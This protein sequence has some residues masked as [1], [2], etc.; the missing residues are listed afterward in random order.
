MPGL[1]FCTT[2]LTRGSCASHRWQMAKVSS[3]ARGEVRSS[4]SW[5]YPRS[6]ERSVWMVSSMENVSEKTVTTT[7]TC[8]FFEGH[9]FVLSWLIRLENYLSTRVASQSAMTQEYGVGCPRPPNGGYIQQQIQCAPR[10]DSGRRSRGIAHS[11]AH[12]GECDQEIDDRAG[13]ANP[14]VAR[15]SARIRRIEMLLFPPT[16]R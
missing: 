13:Y 5:M 11:L 6:R 14:F 4:I 9:S 16:G 7:E 15:Q 12:S 2:T 10:H 1:F 8:I 3:E